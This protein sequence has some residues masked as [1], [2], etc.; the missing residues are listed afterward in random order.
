MLRLF[1]IPLIFM[2]LIVSSCSVNKYI[3]KPKHISTFVNGM[4]FKGIKFR[5]KN[6]T[7]YFEGEI[8]ALEDE[9]IYILTFGKEDELIFLN[10]DEIKKGRI[11]VALSS[12]K[13]ESFSA[14]ALINVLPVAHGWFGI[15]TLPI[16]A[17]ASGS[18]ITDA[19]KRGYRM[20]YPK[21]IDWN[22]LSKFARFPQGMP[23]N[24]KLEEIKR[25]IQ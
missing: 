24:V 10:K 4:Y 3:A 17:A 2:L 7:R 6:F 19:K 5:G 22:D 1:S 14:W 20:R 18:I 11:Y 23:P 8:I 25:V 15:F 13:P 9:G 16:T 12:D 21:E